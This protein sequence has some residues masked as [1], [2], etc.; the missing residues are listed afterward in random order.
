M[1]G[2]GD[3]GRDRPL[4]SWK[5][6]ASFFG[7][8]QRTV[9][10]WESARGLP[11][12]RVPGGN[13]ASVYA[14]PSELERWLR[15]EPPEADDEARPEAASAAPDP[16]GRPDGKAVPA[17]SPRRASGA[18]RSRLLVLAGFVAALLIPSPILYLSLWETPRSR[19]GIERL[20][21]DAAARDLYLGGN[22]QLG[23]RTPAGLRRAVQLFTQSIASDPDFAAAYAGLA[24]AYALLVSY[25]VLPGDDGYPLA[26]AAAERALKL[27]PDLPAAYAALG[28]TAFYGDRDFA[29]SRRLLERS[30][31]LDPGSAETFHWLALTTVL[32][33][34]FDEAV[35]AILRAQELD[36][37]SRA[38]LANKGQ[39]LYRSG[40]YDRAARL[41]S[42][43]VE[44]TPGYAAPHFY[45]ADIYLH[46]GRFQE[47]VRH[48]LTAAELTGDAALR[49]V[50]EA[51]EQGYRRAGQTGL[52]EA[53]FS[54]ECEFA[55]EGEIAS[56]R[57]AKTLA[58]LGRNEEAMAYLAE[59]V[60]AREAD[61]LFLKIDSVFANLRGDPR[62]ADLLVAIGH[63]V[64][65]PSPSVALAGPPD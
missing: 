30:L 17:P 53:M 8:D 22:Y 39:I 27:D 50:Y 45:L 57:V 48:G 54:A 18:W 14:Y 64:D 37:D 63:T 40:Q 19:P 6:I 9:K 1:A 4:R 31:Q 25:Q 16:A 61:A 47:A 15:S 55:H 34:A 38:I 59:A 44:V 20:S 26:R 41:L 36:P 21:G 49:Q 62:F 11:V 2:S 29:E 33:G 46:Q 35:A 51:A 7:R 5:E 3:V 43:L 60:S 42:Q 28:L 58:R 12:H 10:R 24:R 65:Y 23:L 32:T 52:L 13:R 56:Y